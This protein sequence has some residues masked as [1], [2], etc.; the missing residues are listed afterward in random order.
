MGGVVAI[1]AAWASRRTDSEQCGF[2]LRFGRSVRRFAPEGGAEFGRCWSVV[3]DGGAEVVGVPAR[4]PLDLRGRRCWPRLGRCVVVLRAP[5]VGFT[6]RFSAWCGFRPEAARRGWSRCSSSWNGGAT[7]WIFCWTCAGRN[8]RGVSAPPGSLCRRCPRRAGCWRPL[9][10]ARCGCRPG[11]CRR[12][13]PTRTPEGGLCTGGQ[14][15]KHRFG[16][17]RGVRSGSPAETWMARRR[18]VWEVLRGRSG[19]LPPAAS[20]AGCGRRR[21]GSPSG[22]AAGRGEALGRGPARRVSQGRSGAPVNTIVRLGSNVGKRALCAVFIPVRADVTGV[23]RGA[24]W[25]ARPGDDVSVERVLA[26]SVWRVPKGVAARPASKAGSGWVAAPQRGLRLTPGE[27]LGLRPAL[28]RPARASRGSSDLSAKVAA[29]SGFR[30]V[31]SLRSG[32]KT[33]NLR[34]VFA[35]VCAPAGPAPAACGTLL[36]ALVASVTDP[37]LMD[38]LTRLAWRRASDD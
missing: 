5:L 3:H 19:W 7:G 23:V 2:V 13:L 6:A 36:A 31:S 4:S 30:P 14:R 17:C 16:R 25:A 20:W 26:P 1:W 24:A 37:A 15:S 28:R 11:Q 12:R 38:I 9:S 18:V 33:Q 10:R 21:P 32:P 34:S 8:C 22:G 27:P 29:I 35:W